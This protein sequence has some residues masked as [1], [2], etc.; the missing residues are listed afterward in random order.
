MRLIAGAPDAVAKLENPRA[1]YNAIYE[2]P[3]FQEF[4]KID[5]FAALYDTTNIRRLN[6]LIMYLEKE[7]GHP[8][9]ELL[10]RLAGGGVVFAATFAKKEILV[11]VEAKDE[12]LLKKFLA[13]AR[14]IGD[15]ELARQDGAAKI[16]V[17]SYRDLETWHLGAELNLARAGSSL[18]FA[19]KARHS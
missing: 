11:I 19:N 17:K 3:A 9:L 2:H 14:K 10:D 6:Q 18:V 5:V 7:L 12:A 13:L 15:Q 8:R 4:R 16:T 1:L